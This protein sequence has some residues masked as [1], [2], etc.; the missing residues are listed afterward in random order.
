MTAATLVGTGGRLP[1]GRG[2]Q[3]LG[4]RQS[5]DL[6]VSDI[7]VSRVHAQLA[8]E[9]HGTVL[10]DLGSTAGTWVNGEPVTGSQVLHHGDVVQFGSTRWLY[11]EAGRAEVTTAPTEIADVEEAVEAQA[12]FDDLPVVLRQ[13]LGQMAQGW[14]NTRIAGELGV[15]EDDV[16]ALAE[17][18]YD[19][20]G[21]SNRA[22]AVAIAATRGLL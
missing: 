9:E 7:S 5:C 11:E 22:A 4:R 1:V 12:A 18:L 21:V 13:V 14:S 8:C 3:L 6:V 10:T 16:E 15:S 2:E 20:L 17:D 19:R